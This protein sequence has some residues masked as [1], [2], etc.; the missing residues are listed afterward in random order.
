MNMTCDAA[1]ISKTFGFNFVNIGLNRDLH[2]GHAGLGFYRDTL[3]V[4]PDEFDKN[5][6]HRDEAL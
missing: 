3:F 4:V 2:K 6:T 5:V 1:A